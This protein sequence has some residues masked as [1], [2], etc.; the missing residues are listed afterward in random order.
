VKACVDAARPTA[1]TPEPP[2]PVIMTTFSPF[3][4]AA[5][6]RPGRTP[7]CRA[8]TGADHARLPEHVLID[9]VVARQRA[10]MGTRGPGAAEVRPAF[11]T[12][13]G[14]FFRDPAGDFG[15]GASVLQVLAM[16]RDDPGIVVLLE[17]GQTGRPRR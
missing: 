6:E 3:G 12:T 1:G 5:P 17:E 9:L 13:I 4:V 16:L 15:E 11:S 7:A 10:G 8:A 2:A 14:F